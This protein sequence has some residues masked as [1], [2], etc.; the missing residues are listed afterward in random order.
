M[1]KQ[2][3]KDDFGR[4]ILERGRAYLKRNGKEIFK[5]KEIGIVPL[6][7]ISEFYQGFKEGKVEGYFLTEDGDLVRIKAIKKVPYSGKIWDVDVGNDIILVKREDS[8]EAHWL[9]NSE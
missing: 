6:V 7:K 4:G 1:G 9:E 8:K 5:E 2:A 3:S